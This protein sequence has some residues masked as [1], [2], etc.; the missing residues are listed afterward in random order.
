MPP[1]RV[2]G[3]AGAS[4][5]RTPC[6]GSGAVMGRRRRRGGAR[7]LRRRGAARHTP[8]DGRE[9]SETG[10]LERQCSSAAGTCIRTYPSSPAAPARAAERVGGRLV[11][12]CASFFV[13]THA[14]S[15]PSRFS[16]LIF[17]FFLFPLV[18]TYRATFCPRIAVAILA[19]ALFEAAAVV[20]AIPSLL[21]SSC[22]TTV[23]GDMD[24]ALLNAGPCVDACGT[25]AAIC[26]GLSFRQ[27]LHLGLPP[28][29]PVAGVLA[30]APGRPAAGHHPRHRRGGPVGVHRCARHAPRRVPHRRGVT[31]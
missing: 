17:L 8:D 27:R 1:R 31:H 21:Q 13:L 25:S 7:R 4:G 20:T 29:E 15:P 19:L 28:L 26:G 18:S 6:A 14:S 22:P 24:G 16:A 5:I 10:R 12:V 2:A 23:A 11:L 9:G 30:Q 3:R